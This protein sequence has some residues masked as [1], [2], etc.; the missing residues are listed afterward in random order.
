[1]VPIVAIR[2]ISPFV[3]LL[4]PTHYFPLDLLDGFR[5]IDQPLLLY[6]E[7]DAGWM[8]TQATD[9]FS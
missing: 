9:Q 1:M 6:A 5:L 7:L 8:S 2:V 3:I 4:S